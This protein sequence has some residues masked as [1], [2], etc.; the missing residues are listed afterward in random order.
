MQLSLNDAN[1]LKLQ[2]EE[3]KVIVW[4]QTFSAFSVSRHLPLNNSR[5]KTQ[6]QET[7]NHCFF[8]Q[9]VLTPKNDMIFV[10][11]FEGNFLDK[12]LIAFEQRLFSV[13]DN[14]LSHIIA[15]WE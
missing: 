5:P 10:N 12:E 6:R 1:L 2:M 4:I 7:F 3:R 15:T 8:H 9:I 13:S 11:T 14:P